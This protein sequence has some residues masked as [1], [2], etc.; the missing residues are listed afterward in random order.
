MLGF[1][2]EKISRVMLDNK[3]RL[4][5][6]IVPP[7]ILGREWP[8][9]IPAYDPEAAAEIIERVGQPATE[10]A[11][12]DGGVAVAIKLVL[13]RD[14]GL[15]S[16]AIS[17]EWPEF[18]SRLTEQS[19]PAFNLSWIA[20]FPDPANFLT[21]M[22]HSQSPDN[23]IGYANPA[24]DELLDAAEIEPDIAERERLYEEAQQLAIDDSVLLPLFHDIAYTVVRPYV[25]GIIV[26]PVGIL[27]LDRVWIER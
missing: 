16:E 7:G 21:S 20:D 18:S 14:L 17:L 5:Y 8:A 22:F 1:D 9:E 23:Y 12:F 13:E 10:P 26:S 4:A 27:S 25:H 19:M 2:R 11:F 15:K 3:V 6:G 24:M